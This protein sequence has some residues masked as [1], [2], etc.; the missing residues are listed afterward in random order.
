M[1]RYEA[2]WNALRERL[3]GALCAPLTDDRRVV[4]QWAQDQMDLVWNDHRALKE[5]L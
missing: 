3:D 2:M 1:D 5:G 4:V